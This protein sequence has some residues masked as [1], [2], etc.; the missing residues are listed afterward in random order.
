MSIGVR[1]FS[2]Q[3]DAKQQEILRDI[4]F[5]VAS[6]SITTIIGPNGAGKSSLLKAIMGDYKLL[7]GELLL[8]GVRADIN[9]SSE[10]RARSLAMLPQL[11][12]LNFPYSVEEVV[13]L[14]RTPHQTGRQVDDDIVHASLE[15]VEMTAF[16]ARLYPQLSGGEKQRVQIARVLAQIWRAEDCVGQRILILDEPTSSLDLGHQQ[17]L[18]RFLQKFSQSGVTILMVLHDLNIAAHYSDELLAVYKG[19][20]LSQGKPDEIL[21]ESNMRTLFDVE[22]QIIPHPVT[23]KPVVLGL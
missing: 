3:V 1:H 20:V 9:L 14:G 13:R 2:L 17:M 5:D 6:N 18:M 7:S 8:N 15:A 4:S 11:S 21:Q 10:L 22:C 19:E 16:S 23:G 12:L